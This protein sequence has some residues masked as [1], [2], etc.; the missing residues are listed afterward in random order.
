MGQCEGCFRKLGEPGGEFGAFESRPESITPQVKGLGKLVNFRASVKSSGRVGSVVAFD[1]QDKLHTY[2]LQFGDGASPESDWFAEESVCLSSNAFTVIVDT[3]F[4]SDKTEKAIGEEF[5]LDGLFPGDTLLSLYERIE[6]RLRVP[7]SQIH[8]SHVGATFFLECDLSD[9]LCKYGLGEDARVDCFI[10]EYDPTL[11]EIVH[12]GP[13]S[14]Y[15]DGEVITREVVA[16]LYGPRQTD[17][18][19]LLWA[20]MMSRSGRRQSIKG[21]DESDVTLSADR[22]ELLISGKDTRD[23][24][25]S[26]LTISAL[27][28][29]ARTRMPETLEKQLKDCFGE[30]TWA[31]IQGRLCRKLLASL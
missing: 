20:S 16:L 11:I 29:K 28:S 24:C 13:E 7:R 1:P 27:V 30:D 14:E 8:L 9:T 21:C 23:D 17:K 10:T 12:S 22:S 25:E 31:M 5:K 15:Q 3:I 26:R 19:M 18:R 6:K 4:P 2:K